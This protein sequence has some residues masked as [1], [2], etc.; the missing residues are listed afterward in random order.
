MQEQERDASQ[1]DTQNTEEH[2]TDLLQQ[3]STK[4]PAYIAHIVSKFTPIVQQ[5]QL[6][7]SHL[8]FLYSSK[9]YQDALTAFVLKHVLP[10]FLRCFYNN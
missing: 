2:L 8:S 3:L 9:L 7:T 1:D 4:S 10:L 6:N 5:H